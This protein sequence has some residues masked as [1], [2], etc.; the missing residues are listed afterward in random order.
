[1]KIGSI[2]KMTTFIFV[3]IAFFLIVFILLFSSTLKTELETVVFLSEIDRRCTE[4]TILVSELRS[5]PSARVMD[6][7]LSISQSIQDSLNDLMD[8]PFYRERVLKVKSMHSN[9]TTALNIIHVLSEQ[10]EQDGYSI[11][12]VESEKFFLYTSQLMSNTQKI[13]QKTY[14]MIKDAND[15]LIQQLTVARIVTISILSLFLLFVL[16]QFGLLTLKI[17]KP[18]HWLDDALKN[19]H[20]GNFG[21]KIKYSSED[22]LGMVAKVF[23]EM[24]DNLVQSTVSREK[25]EEELIMRKSAEAELKQEKAKAEQLAKE[26]QAANNV[27]NIFLANMSHEMRTPLTGI[28]GTLELLGEQNLNED[29]KYLLKLSRESAKQMNHIVDDLLEV[30][31]ISADSFELHEKYFDMDESL[32]KIYQLFLITAREKGLN[33][34]VEKDELPDQIFADK[35][36]IR[37]I[38][39]QLISNAIKFTPEGTVSVTCEFIK[40]GEKKGELI[41][42]VQ[43]TGIGIEESVLDHIY[44]YFYQKDMSFTKDYQGMGIGLT[45]VKNIVNAMHGKLEITTHQDV[46]S[47]FTVILPVAYYQ[48]MEKKEKQIEE[49]EVSKTEKSHRILSVEDNHINRLVVRKI[50][51]KHGYIVEEAVNGEVALEK[52]ENNHHFDLILMDI[53]MPKMD[54]YEARKAIRDKYGNSAPKMVALTGYQSDEDRRKIQEAGFEGYLGKPYSEKDLIGIIKKMESV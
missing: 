9:S 21:Y 2:F 28:I 15:Q 13:N 45:I 5:F 12:A 3:I 33:F 40:K 31:K 14:E 18:L 32:Q 41:L 26:A 44:D 46:G 34:N 27:K 48:E 50:L 24:S 17:L 10:F 51:E 47:T 54:G 38:L 25:L 22:E 16:Y 49:E 1:M 37:Q 4:N 11:S 36:R 8:N 43:D 23:N 6:Q 42:S 29:S 53:Q 52:V 35:M 30:S 20:S 7:L 39:N 19:I